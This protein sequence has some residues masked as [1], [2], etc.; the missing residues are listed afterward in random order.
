MKS[1]ILCAVLFFI[2]PYLSFAKEIIL[3][4]SERNHHYF[5]NLTK[6]I[7]CEQINS[8]NSPYAIRAS[9]E[10]ILICKALYIGGISPKII[11]LDAPNYSRALI[12]TRNGQATIHSESVWKSEVDEDLFYISDPIIRQSEFEKVFYSSKDIRDEIEK[13]LKEA[14]L[15]GISSLKV[16]KRYSVV[17]SSNWIIDWKT[18]QELG[19]KLL[20]T[21]RY[22]LMHK[23]VYYNR[24][25]L[26]LG[27]PSTEVDMITTN[28]GIQLYPVRGIKIGLK[29]SRHFVISK[30][31]PDALK[32]YN[33]LQNGVKKMRA[34][35]TIER[36]FNES[37]FF[38]PLLKN[39]EK[40]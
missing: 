5:V 38:H 18:L 34:K 27:E 11:L 12:Q 17:S 37:G 23:M 14:H 25:H 39:W 22:P 20:N 6:E 26:L 9:V 31:H 33:A 21:T 3:P 13:A 29:E 4:V 28:Q 32:I 30:K 2:I 24:A 36:A 40:L 1:F 15:Q 7:P 35:G 19:F 16:L 10:M 8:F